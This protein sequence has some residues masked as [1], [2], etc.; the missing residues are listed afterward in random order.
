MRRFIL[1]VAA[2][3]ALPCL[4][5]CVLRT[6]RMRIHFDDERRGS[7]SLAATV[8]GGTKT[9]DPK[10]VFD[11]K[12]T[13]AE[14]SIEDKLKACGFSA[15]TFRTPGQMHI[16]ARASFNYPDELETSLACVPSGW[17]VVNLELQARR[18]PVSL[19]LYD[20]AAARAAAV[21]INTSNGESSVR[22][23]QIESFPRRLF[24]TVPGTIKE[25]SSDGTD[26]LGARFAAR[27]Y[28]TEEVRATLDEE[29]D[30]DALG[31]RLRTRAQNAFQAGRLTATNVSTLRRN[32]YALTVT[33]YQWKFRLQDLLSIL[34]V[35]FGS[36][37]VVKLV[38]G[39]LP[40]GRGAAAGAEAPAD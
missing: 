4:G 10:S 15:L 20:D 36:G 39:R 25:I 35:L 30:Y 18:G 22:V 28:G 16:N 29:R 11:I 14:V 2:L 17:D 37:F 13:E 21:S 27:E 5:S 3:L 19:H 8:E 33:S 12:K 26:I 40:A 23:A 34:A 32:V 9:G 38:R 6:D 24:L 1:V 31:Q 7:F